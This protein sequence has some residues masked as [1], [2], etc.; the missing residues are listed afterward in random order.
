MKE[1][2]GNY[3]ETWWKSV[4]TAHRAY[5]TSRIPSGHRQADFILQQIIWPC[6]HQN[7][8]FWDR[9]LSIYVENQTL[10]PASPLIT[11]RCVSCTTVVPLFL[12][13]LCTLL[14]PQSHIPWILCSMISLGAFYYPWNSLLFTVPSSSLV[15]HM[16]SDALTSLSTLLVA[17]AFDPNNVWAE[18][19]PL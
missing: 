2:P 11:N 12:L 1:T 17:E 5:R 10:V 3:K 14:F 8:P 16:F 19:R 18:F 13:A 9:F 15:Q 6:L 7:R 4:T